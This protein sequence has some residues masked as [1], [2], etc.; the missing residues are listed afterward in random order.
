MM[1][2]DASINQTKNY[3]SNGISFLIFAF[4]YLPESK[5]D[6]KRNKQLANLE[7]ELC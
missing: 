7:V 4:F 3:K 5:S 1:V 6:S 2:E